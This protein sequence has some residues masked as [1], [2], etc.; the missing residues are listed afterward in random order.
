VCEAE[1]TSS[2]P[3][4][5]MAEASSPISARRRVRASHC[6]TQAF[7]HCPQAATLNRS[8]LDFEARMVSVLP[9]GDVNLI[10][11]SRVCRD[12]GIVVTRSRPYSEDQFG[13]PKPTSYTCNPMLKS[14]RR[15]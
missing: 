3:N 14:M 6:E 12:S 10:R 13:A 15:T 8:L 9:P 11:A 7:A 4:A 5:A 2:V 1:N